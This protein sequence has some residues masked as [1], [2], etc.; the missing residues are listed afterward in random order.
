MVLL[1]PK[2]QMGQRV[3]KVLY[4]LLHQHFLSGLMGLT[5]PVVLFQ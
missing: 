4:H 1:P 3:L 5:D 2:D